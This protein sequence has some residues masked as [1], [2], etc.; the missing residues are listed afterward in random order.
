LTA[1]INKVTIKDAAAAWG[2][3]FVAGS[4]IFGKTDKIKAIEGT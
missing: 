2:K 4:S 1:E 3:Y